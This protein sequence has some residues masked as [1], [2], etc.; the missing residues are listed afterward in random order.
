MT[1]ARGHFSDVAL[2]T[3]DRAPHLGEAAEVEGREFEEYGAAAGERDGGGD[4]W[5]EALP[6]VWGGSGEPSG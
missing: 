4:G 3:L 6:R 2:S 5:E 1:I